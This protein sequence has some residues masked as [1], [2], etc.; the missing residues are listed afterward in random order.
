[1][2]WYNSFQSPRQTALPDH[3]VLPKELT[4]VD[5]QIV[6][7][8]GNRFPMISAHKVLAAYSCFLP[9]VVSGQFNPDTHSAVWP[10]TGNYARGGIAISTLLQSRGVAVLPENMSKERFD[11]L[12]K[13]VLD[14]SDVIGPQDQKV[15]SKR[16]MML[17][18]SSRKM[19]RISSFNQFSEYANH[20]G[21]YKVTG[22]ALGHVFKEMQTANPELELKAFVSASGSAGTTRSRRQVKG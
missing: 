16:S 6:L 1:M 14:P 10:S 20:I 8:F 13:W 7:L 5:A 9:R 3:I 15:T 21:H 4:G 22:Q 19:R 18:M 12:D 11:W 2:H 17:V